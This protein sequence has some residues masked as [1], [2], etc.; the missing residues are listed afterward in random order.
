MKIT[1][2]LL[3]LF[4]F[5]I[6]LQ[7][8]SL[9]Y[10]FNLDTYPTPS[11]SMNYIK[12]DPV[13]F[14]VCCRYPNEDEI[15]LLN[16]LNLKSLN[17]QAGFFPSEG[18]MNILNQYSGKYS[19]ELS[20]VFPSEA[21]FKRLNPSKI[22]QLIINSRDFLT[23]GEAVAFNNFKINVRVNINHKEY[24]LPK[25]MKILKL[26]NSHFTVAFKNR[27]LPGVGYA[28]FFNA[29]KTKKVFTSVDKFPYG[30]D[31]LG[32][33]S[34]SNSTIEIFSN[35]YLYLQDV[36]QI[37]KM[38][39]SKVI[40]LGDQSPYTGV[41]IDLIKNIEANKVYLKGFDDSLKASVDIFRTAKSN[42]VLLK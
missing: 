39:I 16:E 21:D 36:D 12:A 5:A 28:N 19:I 38:K 2:K 30:E 22:S 11:E 14:N 9:E 29:L 31:Y 18:E 27:V 17:I 35:E 4:L 7:A 10:H 34:L 42:I 25:H 20:E 3:I 15:K 32:V 37:N 24:P 33:N 8:Q 26:L 1:N 23:L 41:T 40:H 6:S 13:N